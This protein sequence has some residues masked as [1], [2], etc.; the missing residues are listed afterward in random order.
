MNAVYE[1]LID[2]MLQTIKNNIIFYYNEDNNN[3][4]TLRDVMNVIKE[5]GEYFRFIVEDTTAFRIMLEDT[6][7]DISRLPNI[8][9]LR[10]GI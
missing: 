2:L 3:F 5:H 7:K 1:I 4:K 9:D 10:D 6:I 8:Y